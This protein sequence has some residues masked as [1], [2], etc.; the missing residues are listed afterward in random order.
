MKQNIV[1]HRPT[2]LSRRWAQGIVNRYAVEAMIVTL[3]VGGM[4]ELSSNI[5]LLKRISV[6]VNDHDSLSALS[7]DS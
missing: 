2:D 3:A 4:T 7:V 5:E 1:A 6:A